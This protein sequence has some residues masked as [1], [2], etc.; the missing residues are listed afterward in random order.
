MAGRFVVRFG[1][2]RPRVQIP[3]PRPISE[4][5]VAADWIVDWSGEGIERPGVTQTEAADGAQAEQLI[6]TLRK[7]LANRGNV[8]RLESVGEAHLKTEVLDRSRLECD[9]P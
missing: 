8:T 9:G 6:L 2:V 3:G 7:Q 1:T 5:R 4:F